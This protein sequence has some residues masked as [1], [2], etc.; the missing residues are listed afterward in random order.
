M[1]MTV[2]GIKFRLEDDCDTLEC[3]LGNAIYEANMNREYEKADRLAADHAELV[4]AIHSGDYKKM[5]EMLNKY[6]TWF[7]RYR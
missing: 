7:K 1:A 3:K 2:N 6:M 4:L 5:Q